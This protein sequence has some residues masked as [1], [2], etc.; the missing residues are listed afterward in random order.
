MKAHPSKLEIYST[1]NSKNSQKFTQK[2]TQT[3]S[4][5]HLQNAQIHPYC[6]ST[7]CMVH[8]SLGALLLFKILIDTVWYSKGGSGC[9]SLEWIRDPRVVG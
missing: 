5:Y 7:D 9:E 3:I 1:Q 4:K 6:I 8:L 2:L